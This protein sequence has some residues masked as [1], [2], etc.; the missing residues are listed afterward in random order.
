MTK[1]IQKGFT[2]I[3]LMI[4][5]AI[6]G[7]LAAVAIPA[8]QDYTAKAQ[9]SEAYT[10]LGGMKTPVSEAISN[11]GNTDGCTRPNGAVSRGNSVDGIT[12]APASDTT[13]CLLTATF[14]STGVNAKVQGKKVAMRYNPADGSWTCGSDL[15][16]EIKNKACQ[17]GLP[18]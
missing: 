15:G 5:V 16:S 4:V 18:T 6:I 3:E 8:Y 9:T 11:V 12:V 1:Q 2:L 17:D 10:L 14:K 7:I 13:Q